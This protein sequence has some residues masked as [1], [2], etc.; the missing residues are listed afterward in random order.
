MADSRR[1]FDNGFL[2]RIDVEDYF[3]KARELLA[4]SGLEIICA[5]DSEFLIGDVP[6]FSID[7]KRGALGFL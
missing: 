6:A 3:V 7:C 2:F 4:H 1:L 5:E